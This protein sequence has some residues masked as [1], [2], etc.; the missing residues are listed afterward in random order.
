MANANLPEALVPWDVK[1]SGTDCLNNVSQSIIPLA[2]HIPTTIQ[3]NLAINEPLSSEGT[4]TH[5]SLL[6]PRCKGLEGRVY[7]TKIG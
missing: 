5:L 6:P 7:L 1:G 2:M 3:S 4:R